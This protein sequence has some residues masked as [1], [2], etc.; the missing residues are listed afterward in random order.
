MDPGAVPGASTNPKAR[1]AAEL[2]GRIRF[3]M[4]GKDVVFARHD[5]T[6]IGS[7]S[8]LPMT[9]IWH[10]LLSIAR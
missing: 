6:V 7:H 2:R 5:T 9:T 8:E 4:S 1:R 3:D 10:S